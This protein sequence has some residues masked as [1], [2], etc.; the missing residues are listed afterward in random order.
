MS[1]NR[2]TKHGNRETENFSE[3]LEQIARVEN[4]LPPISIGRNQLPLQFTLQKLMELYRIPGLSVAVIDNFKIAWAKGYGVTEA[5]TLN[6][7]TT[8]TMFQAGSVSKPLAA[9]GALWLA[10]QGK[11]LLDEDV[12]QK[13]IAW[14]VPENEFTKEQKVTLRRILSHTAGLTV[15]FFPGYAADS[16]L[17]T[18][19]QILNGEAPANTDPIQVD[20]VPGT[21]W[22]Y[23]GGGV[24]VEQQLMM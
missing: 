17:P 5:G 7:V 14:K 2:Q 13:L 23:S 18:L 21:R 9:V 22:R 10:E 12:N 15:H 6:P 16:Q 8:E 19:V 3:P 4:G 20:F 11:L 1:T 24:V